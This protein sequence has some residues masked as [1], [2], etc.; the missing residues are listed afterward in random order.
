MNDNR[1]SLGPNSTIWLIFEFINSL[2]SEKDLISLVTAP[3]VCSIMT[4]GFL[5]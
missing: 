3:L 4:D 1:E 2:E 5:K